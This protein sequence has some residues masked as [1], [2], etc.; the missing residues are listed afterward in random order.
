MMA[1]E[2]AKFNRQVKKCS[3]HI[4]TG[5]R[6]SAFKHFAHHITIVIAYQM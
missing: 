3:Q 2:T 5:N 1:T 6:E 4:A